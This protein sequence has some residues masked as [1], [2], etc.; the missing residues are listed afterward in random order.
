MFCHLFPLCDIPHT[1]ILLAP[2]AS[3][4]VLLQHRLEHGKIP[5]ILS[6][7]LL[8]QKQ[9][10]TKHLITYKNKTNISW[11]KRGVIHVEETAECVK[12]VCC[13][14]YRKHV[15]SAAESIRGFLPPPAVS[16]F[17]NSRLNN[18]EDL[19]LVWMWLCTKLHAVLCMCERQ[20]AGKLHIQFSRFYPQVMSENGF[21]HAGLALHKTNRTVQNVSLKP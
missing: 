14:L 19:M 11:R 10:K 4:S 5:G 2:L 17:T 7:E 3:I 9:N 12:R 1:W 15:I 8:D 20:T 21:R 6:V 13:V 16:G 18:A